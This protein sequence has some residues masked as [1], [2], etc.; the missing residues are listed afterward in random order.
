MNQE[1]YYM[2]QEKYSTILNQ[3]NDL[4]QKSAGAEHEKQ[5]SR[6]RVR[7]KNQYQPTIHTNE[8]TKTPGSMEDPAEYTV[9]V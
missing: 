7:L 8:E 2:N 1:K 5:T 3:P 6:G 9:L 4:P